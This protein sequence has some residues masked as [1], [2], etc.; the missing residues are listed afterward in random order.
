MRRP[1]PRTPTMRTLIDGYNLM[2]AAGVVGRGVGPGGLE[3]S[4]LALLNFVVESLEPAEVPRTIVV[5]DA[6]AAP[7]GLPRTLEHRG[8]TVRF[9]SKSG[10]ADTARDQRGWRWEGE[11]MSST[12][13][14]TARTDGYV[15]TGQTV[16]PL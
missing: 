15:G 16:G 4:R 2:H 10:S 1:N 6:A 7:P 14:D 8:L 11:G 13:K 3:R 9:A 12:P 5:F